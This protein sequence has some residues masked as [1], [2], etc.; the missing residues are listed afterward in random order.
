MRI[1]DGHIGK[2]IGNARRKRGRVPVHEERGPVDRDR[3]AVGENESGRL[4]DGDGVNGIAVG[5]GEHVDG[6]AKVGAARL[7]HSRSLG[8]GLLQKQHGA[9]R[10]TQRLDQFR[11]TLDFRVVVRVIDA[12]RGPNAFLF[13]VEVK[14]IVL[15]D[16]VVRLFA[17][18]EVDDVAG[19][20]VNEV[21][22]LGAGRS[23]RERHLHPAPDDTFERKRG[24]D[25]RISGDN[26]RSGIGSLTGI[27]FL[28]GIGALTGIGH[29]DVGQRDRL[30]GRECGR[31][32][33]GIEGG[34]PA[35][36]GVNGDFL[37]YD[38]GGFVHDDDVV[39]ILRLGEGVLVGPSARVD[40]LGFRHTGLSRKRFLKF[41]IA[42]EHTAHFRNQSGAVRVLVV[43]GVVLAGRRPDALFALDI[44]VVIVLLGGVDIRLRPVLDEVEAIPG[45]VH[46][47]REGLAGG[48]GGGIVPDDLG[49]DAETV[50]VELVDGGAVRDMRIVVDD[51]GRVVFVAG[52]EAVVLEEFE[53]HVL[54]LEYLDVKAGVLVAIP[55][56]ANAGLLVYID[57]IS[58]GLFFK[59]RDVLGKRIAIRSARDASDRLDDG[60][61]LKRAVVDA[62][63]PV[64]D[65]QTVPIV[66]RVRP[67][68]LLRIGR[69]DGVGVPTRILTEDLAHNDLFAG[70]G[71][72]RDG[73]VRSDLGRGV[74][75][76]V[77][78]AVV[79]P[80]A[81]VIRID[82][83][84]VGAEF[85][86]GVV[87]GQIVLDVADVPLDGAGDG[88]VDESAAAVRI[89]HLI[90]VFHKDPVGEEAGE[91]ALDLAHDVV[92]RERGF[93]TGF[94]RACAGAAVGAGAGAAVGAC[95]C[96]CA[97]IGAG[98][99]VGSLSLLTAFARVD[100][101]EGDGVGRD[102]P[103]AFDGGAAAALRRRGG[104]GESE[105]SAGRPVDAD[106]DRRRGVGYRR[107]ES[108]FI[109]GAPRDG[110]FG[111]DGG[112]P[113]HAGNIRLVR[114]EVAAENGKVAVRNRLRLLFGEAGAVIHHGF[115]ESA[116][117]FF[118]NGE[119]GLPEFKINLVVPG[120]KVADVSLGGVDQIVLLG[121]TVVG[122]NDMELD[123][124]T[125]FRAQ[126]VQ[127]LGDPV[128]AVIGSDA[129]SGLVVVLRG[130]VPAAAGGKGQR[131]D[132]QKSQKKHQQGESAFHQFFLSFLKWIGAKKIYRFIV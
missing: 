75:I 28:T 24:S 42:P 72:R 46:G 76:A 80:F 34:L 63:T 26:G 35:V 8:V 10:G 39:V 85:V 59:F 89:F 62:A 79:V 58:V 106:L 118:V 90:S 130:V 18:V 128:H 100:V 5:F 109:A 52:I 103:G 51:R 121:R 33:A 108:V 70:V 56:Q 54:G 107:R 40:L 127:L 71:R 96:A 115:L 68:G 66:L 6:T 29:R 37:K 41:H 125:V 123:V 82:L 91:T 31:F 67:I 3:I 99:G 86:V 102:E 20:A 30:T 57:V 43:G 98:A 113:R 77:A 15:G 16:V 112:H 120:H 74:G 101:G 110:G 105:A 114:A 111:L 65:Q 55:R 21:E 69:A 1:H 117:L 132:E 49:R 116:V 47:E 23:H 27:G 19:F 104:A 61:L 95:A 83:I 126:G 36:C 9:R 64:T 122:G 87:A 4:I 53:R 73:S 11:A 94:A 32:H 119:R 14:V 60:G 22:R 17:R 13:Y 92:G 12:H 88:A 7:L 25:V 81:R 97:A 78:D 45:P 48:G 50:R 44:V 124:K 38:A 2:P 84:P 129:R 131:R 93:E